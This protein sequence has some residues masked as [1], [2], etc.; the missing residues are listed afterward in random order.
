MIALNNQ[1]LYKYAARAIVALLYIAV[2]FP[3]FKISQFL[4]PQTF[5]SSSFKN[6][7]SSD[8]IITLV[9]SLVLLII[10]IFNPHDIKGKSR[11]IGHNAWIVAFGKQPLLM[12]FLT[13]VTLCIGIWASVNSARLLD[14]IEGTPKQLFSKQEVV[15]AV[16]NNPE[17]N[18]ETLFPNGSIRKTTPPAGTQWAWFLLLTSFYGFFIH[19]RA[20]NATEKRKDKLD[21][22]R[23]EA[24]AAL[25]ELAPA[26]NF[27]ELLGNYVD[28]VEDFTFER[29][30]FFTKQ[31]GQI[32]SDI[33]ELKKKFNASATPLGEK[34]FAIYEKEQASLECEDGG[35]PLTNDEKVQK[36]TIQKELEKL[37]EDTNKKIAPL[38]KNVNDLI[39]EQRKYIRAAL[40]AM[41]RLAAAF[42]QATVSLNSSQVYRANIMLKLTADTLDGDNETKKRFFPAINVTPSYILGFNNVYSVLIND[43]RSNLLNQEG[44][45]RDFKPDSDQTNFMMPVF[46][47]KNDNQL[48]GK[49]KSHNDEIENTAITQ[50]EAIEQPKDLQS[51]SCDDDA[52]QNV[53]NQYNMFGAPTCIQTGEFDFVEDTLESVKDWRDKGG[54]TEVADEAEQYYKSNKRVRSLLSIPLSTSRYNK[55]DVHPDKM[56]AALNIICNEPGMLG[57]ERKT[58]QFFHITRPI[59]ISLSRMLHT[60][61]RLLEI[62]EPELEV[63]VGK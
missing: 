37:K 53:M 25:I 50:K 59:I 35:T 24:L 16:N 36:E 48:V 63:E 47:D 17:V 39:T 3:F 29:F 13:L 14:W 62:K 51:L 12:P 41:G 6:S 10:Y 1:K 52:R 2:L 8:Y 7:L 34:L 30:S 20:V 11:H 19:Y 54:L 60:H 26:S 38:L 9:L 45:V 21:K 32:R 33:S 57:N 46:L 18:I 28:I 56:V 23:N 5:E 42:E 4:T 58:N 61:I 31:A 43:D 55:E 15:K 27:H 44:K 22:E 49:A 40:F